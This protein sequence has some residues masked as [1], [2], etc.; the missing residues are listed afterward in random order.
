MECGIDGI[1]QDVE[2]AV[3]AALPPDIADQDLLRMRAGLDRA[4]IAKRKT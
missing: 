4:T 1:E 2:G 3:V